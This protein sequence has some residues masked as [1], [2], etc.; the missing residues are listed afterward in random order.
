MSTIF[1]S[2]SVLM[3]M[4]VNGKEIKK[5]IVIINKY[6]FNIE[7][8]PFNELSFKC[9]LLFVILLSTKSKSVVFIPSSK[10]I[11]DIMKDNTVRNIS[12]KE[13]I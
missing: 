8:N 4:N 11:I 1:G 7:L 2:I 10:Y 3:N 13:K 9:F 6:L 5:S 12:L